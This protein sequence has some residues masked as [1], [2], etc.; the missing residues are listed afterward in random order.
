M[1]LYNQHS[2]LCQWFFLLDTLRIL[3]R[4]KFWIYK[5]FIHFFSQRKLKSF[6]LCVDSFDVIMASWWVY[7]NRIAASH[8][9]Q[10]HHQNQTTTPK[11]RRKRI[12]AEKQE[13][14]KFFYFP[15][16]F[17]VSICIKLRRY[18]FAMLIFLIR[19]CYSMWQLPLSMW[20][21]TC[22]FMNKI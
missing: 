19:D 9:S 20:L 7:L 5:I 17:M 10:Q 18:R 12:I 21:L 11:K 3:Q 13:L 1:P 6:V 15:E 16:R 14:E 2:T 8:E 4:Q 22:E